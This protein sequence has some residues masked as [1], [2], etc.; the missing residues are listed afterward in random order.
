MASKG[1]GR[2]RNND[3]K[4]KTEAVV[5]GVSPS[6]NNEPINAQ[7]LTTEA[8]P[9]S[10][11]SKKSKK[12]QKRNNKDKRKMEA[13][14]AGM[15]PSLNVEPPAADP[16]TPK[17]TE[18]DPATPKVTEAD[19]SIAEAADPATP[20]VTNMASPKSI[21]KGKG[22]KRNNDN[23]HG[24]E[25]ATTGV[26][27]LTNDEPIKKSQKKQ[28][29]NNEDKRKMKA[30]TAG[31]T[32]SLDVEPPA[33]DPT[34]SD[35]TEADPATP[36]ATEADSS[37]TKATEADP[38]IPE[39]TEADPSIP[40]ATE[41][42]P[43]T[44]AVPTPSV[45]PSMNMDPVD[46][47]GMEEQPKEGANADASNDDTVITQEKTMDLA[48]P[49]IEAIVAQEIINQDDEEVLESD[50]AKV[51]NQRG[52]WLHLDGMQLDNI[53]RLDLIIVRY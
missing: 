34:T 53:W 39:A 44:P 35:K 24:T 23:E 8:D 29:R 37:I 31:M 2:K 45:R 22:R 52:E 50:K 27:P 6:S 25:V 40:N 19:P 41:A 28:K 48:T 21:S 10:P 13:A 5:A 32:L 33:A 15:T 46:A 47:Q 16:T 17:A 43:A 11:S 12:I 1:K 30:A 42:D 49:N 4:H 38:S 18:A 7:E 20:T 14:T 9:A 36:K 26:P 51:R 3:N